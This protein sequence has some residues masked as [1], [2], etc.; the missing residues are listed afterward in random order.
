MKSEMTAGASSSSSLLPVSRPPPL[1]EAIMRGVK[2]SGRK[3]GQ[4]SVRRRVPSGGTGACVDS[5]ELVGSHVDAWP[6]PWHPVPVAVPP[7]AT[8]INLSFPRDRAKSCC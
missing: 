6:S 1:Q 7:G 3:Q 5:P 4:G 2:P 8:N